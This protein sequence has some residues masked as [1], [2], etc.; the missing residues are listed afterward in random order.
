[1]TDTNPSDNYIFKSKKG[2]NREI[3]AQI[4]EQKK[5]PSWMRDFRL[6]ALEIFEHKPMPTWGAD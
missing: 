1:M 6:K 5:E 2:I 3:V 4:S